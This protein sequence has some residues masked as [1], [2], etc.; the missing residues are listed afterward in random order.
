M[1]KY[2]MY[3]PALPNVP[4]QDKPAG[5]INSPLW[6]YTENPI[7][8]RNPLPGVARIFNSAVMPF[9]GK[10]VGVFRGEQTNGVP[11]IYL[12]WSQDAIHWDFE[13]EKIPFVDEDGKPFMPIYAYDPR[14]VKVEDTYY[15]IWCQDFYGAA[16][17]IAKTKDFKSF[18]RIENPFLPFNRNA[19]L[20]PRKINGNFVL[21]SRP[22]DSG[23]T[24]FGDIFIS[25]SPDMTYWGKHRHV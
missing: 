14:L 21:M 23:H 2:T 15:I 19:V 12:G 17:G 25:E 1:S 7:I 9:G 4:W 24:P 8:D 20:F 6:R 18:V 16:I 5:H 3:A 22:S 10:F 11:Y 13:P